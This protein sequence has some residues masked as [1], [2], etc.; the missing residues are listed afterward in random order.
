ARSKVEGADEIS[1][2]VAS[3]NLKSDC[4]LARVCTGIP[5]AGAGF[6]RA[7][8]MPDVCSTPLSASSMQMVNCRSITDVMSLALPATSPRVRR[9][10]GNLRSR[11][12]TIDSKIASMTD[13]QKDSS[14]QLVRMPHPACPMSS[15]GTVTSVWGHY[16]DQDKF[17][18][19]FSAKTMNYDNCA[20]SGDLPHAI[21][22]HCQRGQKPTSPN[23][24]DFFVL[25]KQ[26]WLLCGVADGHGID[27]HHVSHFVQERL[28][29]S[30]LSRRKDIADDWRGAS[31]SAFLEVMEQMQVDIPKQCVESGTT[32]SVVWMVTDVKGLMKVRTAH[33]GDS[34][35]VY[36]S[37]RKGEV[38]WQAE[39]LTDV[40]KPDRKDEAARIEKMGGTVIPSPDGSQPA[41]L[42][43]PSGDMAMS[44]AMGDLDAHKCGLVAEPECSKELILED[45]V[46]HMLLIGSDG[47][48]DMLTPLEAVS[49]VGKFAPDDTQRAAERLC[50][51]AQSRW[52]HK[53]TQSGVI[54]DIT[55]IVIRPNCFHQL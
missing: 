21:G 18:P 9:T 8:T 12:L 27:G 16:N 4:E 47:I 14:G 44:R 10:V 6:E 23:Q 53:V 29:K 28:P 46:D 51:K 20:V 2:L 24:D 31:S 40:H 50:A 55:L 54:D 13:G 26:G 34:C 32:A 30:L 43:V 36:G 33:V 5:T 38:N 15:P 35:I 19:F 22:V 41:R 39:L 49:I 1:S 25:Q 48:W 3:M 52:Q 7:V 37:K 11:K 17:Q 45:G 42:A